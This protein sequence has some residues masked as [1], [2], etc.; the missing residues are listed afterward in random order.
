M[1]NKMNQGKKTVYNVYA[2]W[3]D[4]VKLFRAAMRKGFSYG[5]INPLEDDDPNVKVDRWGVK[6][7]K[8][9]NYM[10]GG[11]YTTEYEKAWYQVEVLKMSPEEDV[12]RFYGTTCI[13]TVLMYRQYGRKMADPWFELYKVTL[14]REY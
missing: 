3:T 7:F 11:F 1:I 14:V 6:K 12:A 9:N 10:T 13:P 4:A 5:S 2:S 8:F